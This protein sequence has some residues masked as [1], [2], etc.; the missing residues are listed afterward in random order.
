[1]KRRDFMTGTGT[2]LA[3]GAS[4]FVPGFA[5]AQD[6]NAAD[7]TFT[8]ML[9]GIFY[10]QLTLSP[11]FATMLGLD[12]GE[13]AGLKSQLSDRSAKGREE[14]LEFNR[15][16][17]AKV[18][19]FDPAPL[20]PAGKR[21]RELALYQL[22]QET[23]AA[24]QFDLERALM[25]YRVTQ[26][27]G[28]YF[29][30]PDFL[31]SQHTVKTKAD[32]QAYLAR[33][34][35]F[36]EALDQDTQ[37]Q[38][39]LATRGIV[40]PGWSL[41]L[42]LA[43]MAKLRA[44]APLE[45]GMVNS[46]TSRA[47]QAGIAGDWAAKAA[48]IVEKSVYPALDRQMKLIEAQRSTTPAGD[49]AWRFPKGDEVYAEALKEA[50]TTDYSPE[51]IHKIGLEQVADLEARLGTVLEKAG[52][53]QGTVGQRLAE[54]NARADQLYPNTDEG[55]EA[56][57]TSLNE[58]LRAMYAKLPQAFSNVPQDPLEIRR[59]P[60]EIQDG[61]SN[62]YY[63]PAALD[64]S[65]D[66]IYWINLKDTADWPKYS[67]PSLT[68]HEGVPGHHLQQ[69]YSQ[70][71]GDLPLML[72]NN[73]ISS[74]GEGWA[75]YAEQLSDELGGYSGVETAGYLQSFLFRAVRLVVDTGIHHYQW[76]RE[77]ATDYM[78]ETVGFARP[79]SQ[80]EIERYCVLIG[81]ACSYKMG[82]IIWTKTRAKAQG[83]LG[84]KFSLPWFHEILTEGVM[85]LT[86]LEK[87]V[88]ERIAARMNGR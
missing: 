1:M 10:E 19:T 11:E 18:E 17:L 67:L 25:P 2:A 75:L 7:E 33:L 3:L 30:I 85:P 37:V 50:T 72:A 58:G 49:G 51:D 53:T 63:S 62:G 88:D 29:D 46:L 38:Q 14:G 57:I 32:A 73:F 64:G 54:L 66:A 5:A 69:G 39:D 8:K 83:V 84:D 55:R 36:A 16:A 48:R 28:A 81:Q 77:K 9:D 40:A 35:E 42:A 21:N 22:R 20:S 86:M 43:Q 71:G 4:G 31:N 79:R 45:S 74:Y 56:L 87:R 13:R 27:S 59:V 24:A 47:Q 34:S 76:S 61:A 26:M 52:L 82:H 41:D 6:G 68:Y 65:R 44:S 60:P 80:R 23:V 12:S 70:A 78:V 15:K